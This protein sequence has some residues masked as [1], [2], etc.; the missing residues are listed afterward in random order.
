MNKIAII[1][2]AGVFPEADDIDEFWENLLLGK[3][4]ILRGNADNDENLGV[5]K[6]VEAR[7]RIRDVFNFD[8]DFFEMPEKEAILSDPQNRIFLECI[9]RTFEGAGY[10]W[11]NLPKNVA[12]YAS[13]APSTYISQDAFS[14]PAEKMSCYLL[15]SQDFFAT[16]ISYKLNFMGESINVQTACSSSLAAVYLACQSLN[17]HRCDYAIAGGSNIFL[18]QENGYLFQ[19]GLI[20]SHDGF[21]RPFDAEATGTVESNA[22]GTVLL[23]RYEDA[24]KDG[25]NIY[26]IIKGGAMNNDGRDKLG[27]TAPGISGQTDVICKALLDADVA[28]EKI[29]FI[30]THGTATKLGD[31]I[32]IEALKNVF[33]KERNIYLGAVK[34]NIGHTIRASGIV[35]LMK[36]AL[37]LKYHIIPPVTNHLKLNPELKISDTGFHIN[38]EKVIWD[39]NNSPRIAGVSSFGFG[40]TNVHL[41]LEEYKNS[42][43]KTNNNGIKTLLLSARNKDEMIKLQSMYLEFL[44]E[45]KD[46][47]LYDFTYTINNGRRK[48]QVRW[49]CQFKEYKELLSILQDEISGIHCEYH[50]EEIDKWV[51]EG[52][53]GNVKQKYYKL[54]LPVYPLNK[55]KYLH[56]YAINNRK[57]DEAV[58]NK[59]KEEIFSTRDVVK[60]A[61]LEWSPDKLFEWDKDFYELGIESM[62]YTEII[63]ECENQLNIN[64]SWREAFKFNTPEKLVQLCEKIMR[65][66]I[67]SAERAK[68]ENTI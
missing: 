15:N 45:N 27:Y 17:S 58:P 43:Q 23:K 11:D 34:G 47:N 24:V 65:E 60:K 44:Q 13:S 61:F 62:D 63:I 39:N 32:E 12:V 55:R 5:T 66:K 57:I 2:M 36:T 68:D 30:E 31:V 3:D 6:K 16:R 33:G 29:G 10:N 40:G 19:E 20:Y 25:D 49:G 38:T 48:F 37:I 8:T 64:I 53:N 54:V 35:G 28:P 56:D 1:G 26:A 59:E 41:I 50:S 7:G 14:T 42:V 67:G 51:N 4:C 46:I 52:V 21:C 9:W 22:I 18:P